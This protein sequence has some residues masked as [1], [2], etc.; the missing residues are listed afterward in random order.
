M[1]PRSGLYQF[2]AYRETFGVRN[3]AKKDCWRSRGQDV[4]RQPLCGK[5]RQDSSEHGEYSAGLLHY[6]AKQG[7]ELGEKSGK[8]RPDINRLGTVGDGMGIRGTRG[9]GKRYK[10][11]SVG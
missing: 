6:L 8:L 9:V 10:G 7:L 3:D 1:F 2:C 11:L 5:G 4:R